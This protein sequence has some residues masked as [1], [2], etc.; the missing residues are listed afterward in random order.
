MTPMSLRTPKRYAPRRLLPVFV[1]LAFAPSFA[2]AGPLAAD[3]PIAAKAPPPAV[4]VAAVA[5]QPV[6]REGRYI[7]TIQAIQLVDVKARVE[8]FLDQLAFDQGSM[9]EAG[10]L[11]YRIDPAPFQAALE[12]ANAQ[13]AAAVAQSS[14]AQASLEDAQAQFVRFSALVGKGD[15]SQSQYDRAKASRDEAKAAVDQAKA[16]EL[17][18]QAQISTAKINLGYTTI[19]SP[20]AGRIGATNFT[21][22]NLVGPSSNTLATVVQLDPIRAVFSIP[23]AGFVRF[24]ERIG[25]KSPAE[26]RAE[27]VPELVLPTGDIYPHKGTIAFTNNQIDAGT[28]TVAIYADFPNPKG[29]LLPGQFVTA[30]LHLAQEERLPVVPAAAIQQTR[31]GNQVFVVGE[32]NRVEIRP[33]T[34]SVQV[35]TGF[36]VTSGLQDGEIVVVSG[37]QKVK[38]GMVVA[39][40]PEP[41]A[42]QAPQA[43]PA[44][45]P[46]AAPARAPQ[47]VPSPPAPG[48]GAAPGGG[49]GGEGSDQGGSASGPGY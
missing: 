21:V 11:L 5:S 38:P 20:I 26:A 3:G 45:Q 49:Q 46:Q 24:R 22:G 13:Y 34:L 6:N 42:A 48:P 12:G 32:D 37:T 15:T 19:T 18:A 14:S 41:G 1:A 44:P 39:P 31:A 35:G 27:F 25:D 10:Q 9:I 4:V 43:A 8:G 28:G 33:V 29:E 2:L 47:A 17:Q 40:V 23:S 7:G 30:L 16:A 36:A